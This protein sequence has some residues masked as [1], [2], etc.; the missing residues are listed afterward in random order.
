MGD[1]LVIIAQQLVDY[2]DQVRIKEILDAHTIVFEPQQ[3]AHSPSLA[4]GLA[5]E[6]KK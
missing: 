2:P 3:R 4:A 6:P 5:S 1:L